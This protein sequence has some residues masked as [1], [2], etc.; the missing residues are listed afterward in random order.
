MLG[1]RDGPLPVVGGI[2]PGQVFVWAE[3]LLKRVQEPFLASRGGR[4]GAVPSDGVST[5]P[6]LRAGA[7]T[8]WVSLW[9]A[10]WVSQ[11]FGAPEASPHSWRGAGPGSVTAVG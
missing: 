3:K 2:C 6:R 4:C 11:P 8:V 10:L 5:N 7:L 9:G 1:N